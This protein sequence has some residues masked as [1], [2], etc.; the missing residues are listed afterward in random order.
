MPSLYV[1]RTIFNASTGEVLQLIPA[2]EAAKASVGAADPPFRP[3]ETSLT[4]GRERRSQEKDQLAIG[5]NS[6]KKAQRLDEKWLEQTNR[7][8]DAK[9]QLRE[10][11]DHRLVGI[12]ADALKGEC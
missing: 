1:H 10:D 12:I 9:R 6:D 11:M 2:F 7:V 3:P 5:L 8:L 4:S